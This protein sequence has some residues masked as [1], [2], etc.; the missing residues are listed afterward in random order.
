MLGLAKLYPSL[1][2]VLKKAQKESKYKDMLDLDPM[3]YLE[4]N[5]EFREKY[6]EY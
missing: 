3:D 5:F 6:S 2:K 1:R 4:V